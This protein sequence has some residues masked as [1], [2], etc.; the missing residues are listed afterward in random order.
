MNRWMGVYL[1]LSVAFTA[2]AQSIALNGTISNES[3]KPIAGAI[4]SLSNQS[5]QDTTDENGRYALTSAGMTNHVVMRLGAD[6]ISLR[7]GIISLFLAKSVAVRIDLFDLQGRLLAQLFN[8]HVAAGDYRF[9][10]GRAVSAQLTVISVTIGQHTSTFRY[11]PGPVGNSF[12]SYGMAQPDG[13]T[14]ALINVPASMDTLVVWKPGYVLGLKPVASYQGE[15]DIT[16]DS[17]TLGRFSFFVT[18]I[19]AVLELSGNDS[20]FGG[21]FRFGMTG[22]GAGLRGADSICSCIAEKSMPGSSVKLWRAF[23]S[24]TA[25]AK[26]RQ[27]NAIERIGNGPWYDRLG[28]LLAPTRADL[29]NERPMNGD[30]V[31]KN[32]L[33]N[34]DGIPNHKPDGIN[35]VDNH[36]FVTGSSV[37]GTLYNATATCEDWTSVTASGSPRCGFSWPRGSGGGMM[38]GVHWISGFDA[39]GCAR[40]IELV[41]NNLNSKIIGNAGGYG[42]F[43][44]FALTP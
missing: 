9:E 13:K 33:P 4:V 23:L 15:E 40:G 3:G 7:N 31:I 12:D 18:S 10:I 44:C 35:T 24:V 30:P 22:P 25:D 1:S 39:G 43:Y 14:Q 28:R 8:R 20:G 41:L 42:G 26:G 16:L 37:N 29:I 2:S 32:D 17:I 36:H 5:P 6:H 27:V 34:E 38:G 21:D 19:E 11:I